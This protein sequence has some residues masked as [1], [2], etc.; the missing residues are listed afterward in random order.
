MD[1]LPAKM[2]G[3]PRALLLLVHEVAAILFLMYAVRSGF[4]FYGFYSK[5]PSPA[6]EMP[7]GFLVAIVP[8]ACALM[9]LHHAASAVSLVR[10]LRSR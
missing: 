4:V 8:L 5:I 2:S 1:F 3:R 7:S 10:G 6:M 9:I